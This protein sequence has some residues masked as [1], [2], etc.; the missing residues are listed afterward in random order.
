MLFRSGLPFNDP[1]DLPDSEP[2]RWF[3]ENPLLKGYLPLSC[4]IPFD[5]QAHNE[6]T[7]LNTLRDLPDC[8]LAPML[9]GLSE[10]LADVQFSV[11]QPSITCHLHFG[12][13][14]ELPRLLQPGSWTPAPDPAIVVRSDCVEIRRINVTFRVHLE[15]DLDQDGRKIWWGRKIDHDTLHRVLSARLRFA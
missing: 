14:A 2:K 15:D 1:N 7:Q 3:E 13:R 11:K 10:E 12:S 4:Q 6:G 5:E 9:S 8:T